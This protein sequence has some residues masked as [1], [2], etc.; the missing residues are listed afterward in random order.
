MR[1]MKLQDL[2]TVLQIE[3]AAELFEPYWDD[4]EASFPAALPPFM[5]PEQVVALRAFTNLN[6]DVDE[7][8]VAVARQ[9]AGS[10]VLRHLAWH[11]H[12]LLYAQPDYPSQNVRNWPWLE[13]AL[14]PN[15][16]LFYLLAIL[17]TIPLMRAFH[18][19]RGV[20]EA[21]SRNTV[22]HFQELSRLK[23][24][25]DEQRW[26]ILRSALYWTRYHAW[27]D[28]YCLGRMEYMVRPFGGLVKVYRKR[29][30]DRVLALA[31]EGLVF[32][33]EGY[34]NA[35]ETVE[36]QPGNWESTFEEDATRAVG[37]PVHPTGHGV[38]K[39]VELP[40]S[41]WEVVLQSGDMMLDIHI[42][43]GGGFTP[44]K[45]QASMA[46]ALEFFTRHFPDRPY[47]GF[48]C[49]SWILDPGVA[50]WYR[51]D[52]NMV[53]WQQELYLFPWP[54]G[55]RTGVFFAFD[56]DDIDLA[57]APRNTSLQAAI[58][59]HLSQGGR[60]RASGM[61][62]L[63]EDFPHYG[64]QWYRTRWGGELLGL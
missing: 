7:A 50:E 2:L 32:T 61:F 6:P 26:T 45:C 47:N 31:K 37:Y 24:N 36:T 10:E 15:H 52:S 9:V 18:E 35:G 63:A 46:E 42:P 40:L 51:P 21:V 14:G 1:A 59:D 43:A 49:G 30:T 4:S 19:Q 12:R 23:W 64:D 13:A 41:E 56:Q 60:M 54:S 34:L 8:L 48:C 25:E 38:R 20:P 33:A 29:G 39:Q 62:M 27:G 55:P 17:G 57:T 53:K 22:S 16:G 3:D 5:D 44:E 11:C 28:L 58:I